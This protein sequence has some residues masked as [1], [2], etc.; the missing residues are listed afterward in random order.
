M[1]GLAKQGEL[2]D[3]ELALR[4][5]KSNHIELIYN[6]LTTEAELKRAKGI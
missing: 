1:Q 5:A 3:A 6:Y 2:L 4:Q